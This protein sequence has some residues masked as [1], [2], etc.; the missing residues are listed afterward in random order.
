MTNGE[1][2]IPSSVIALMKTSVSV[3]TLLASCHAD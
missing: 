1:K 3:A 2:K